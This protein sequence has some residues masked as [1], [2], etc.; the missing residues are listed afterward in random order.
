MYKLKT[1]LTIIIL[2]C[3]LGLVVGVFF[4]Y[5]N[6]KFDDLF[7]VQP[8][9]KPPIPD[10]N[11][12]DNNIVKEATSENFVVKH[13][14]N[15][16]ENGSILDFNASEPMSFYANSNDYKVSIYADIS[17]T[18]DFIVDDNLY[19]FNPKEDIVRIF[20]YKKGNQTFSL[21]YENL[22]VAISKMYPEQQVTIDEAFL[23]NNYTFILV[24]KNSKN[25]IIKTF[26]LSIRMGKV[27]SVS[28]D[29]TEIEF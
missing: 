5:N 4:A 24:M 3:I 23:D 13:K 6:G 1:L 17:N 10:N 28:F 22:I 29:P 11:L 20:D 2:L 9:V 12:S 7:S 16:V 15:V 14:D 21:E 8:Q 18:L 19:A 27:L 25:E 26:N